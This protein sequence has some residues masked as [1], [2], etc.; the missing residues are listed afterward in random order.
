MVAYNAHAKDY[1]F[2]PADQDGK[3]WTRKL[4]GLETLCGHFVC[5]IP[6]HLFAVVS[7]FFDN[8]QDGDGFA[9]Y[10]GGMTIKFATPRTRAE[11]AGPL[12][13][14]WL[15]ARYLAPVIA[16]TTTRGPGGE[17]D[18]MYEYAVPADDKDADRWAEAT[19]HW[20]DTPKTLLGM[21]QELNDTW[22]PLDG[23]MYNLHLHIA[24]AAEGEGDF[25][26]LCASQ[27]SCFRLSV[28]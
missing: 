14:A 15:S 7:S 12:R 18:W 6:N 27:C 1:H 2:G 28:C 3:R 8:S 10:A 4:Y 25:Q 16:C 13:T 24:P 19:I 20:H 21:D 23:K 9:M 5:V 26:I 17:H 11:I 22:W